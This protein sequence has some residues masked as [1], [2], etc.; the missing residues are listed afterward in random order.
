MSQNIRGTFA[1]GQSSGVGQTSAELMIPSGVTSAK[2]TIPNDSTHPV[3][4]TIDAS[5]TV[6]TQKSTNGG[7]TWT[8]QTT[9]NSAQSATAI[10]VAHGE[11]WRLVLVTQQ[12]GKSMSYELSVQS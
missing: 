7:Q 12:A 9:Y 10:T 8:D 5:N 2:L 1:S 6:K 3:N 4:S 11:V